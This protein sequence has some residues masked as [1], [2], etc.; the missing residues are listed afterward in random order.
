M[1]KILNHM[2]RAPLVP[3]FQHISSD[4]GIFQGNPCHRSVAEMSRQ[5]PP[6]SVAAGAKDRLVAPQPQ[7][8]DADKLDLKAVEHCGI[9]NQLLLRGTCRDKEEQAGS[10]LKGPF[11]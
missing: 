10:I 11:E 8:L 1:V 6:L 9:A 5:D 7:S 2:V 4:W 3:G